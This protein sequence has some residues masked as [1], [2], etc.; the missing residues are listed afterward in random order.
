M[1][2]NKQKQQTQNLLD[3]VPVQTVEWVRKS[4]NTIT[5]KKLKTRNRLMQFLIQRMGR[6][7]EFKIH[8]DDYGSL[9]WENCDGSKTVHEI[10]ERL[11][12]THGEKIEPVYERLAAFMRILA[13]QKFIVYKSPT[14]I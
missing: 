6:S 5:L 13:A 14:D 4:D 2:K 3:M 1:A 12:E 8:L 10:G 7:L 11:K 9:V